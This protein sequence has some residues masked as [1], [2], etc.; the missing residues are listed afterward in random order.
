MDHKLSRSSETG[1]VVRRSLAIA[2]WLAVVLWGASPAAAYSE[3]EGAAEP[4][5]PASPASNETAALGEAAP[6]PP[7]AASLEDRWGAIVAPDSVTPSAPSADT[8]VRDRQ[9]SSGWSDFGEQVF[10]RLSVDYTHNW[11]SF[12]GLP[13]LT[14]LNN[15]GPTFTI[16]EDGIVSFPE[17]FEN[18]DDRLYTRLNFGTKGF[19]SDRLNTFFSV[20][21]YSDLDGTSSGSPF[22]SYL[23]SY[24]GRNRLELVNAYFEMNGIGSEDGFFSNGHLRVGRQYVHSYTNQLYPLGVTVMDG[25][26]ADF[27][28]ERFNIGG[29]VGSRP[30]LWSEPDFRFVT[31]F[32]FGALLGE[33]AYFN[34]DILYYADAVVQNFTIEP[35]WA[36]RWGL[37][38]FFRMVEDNPVDI[39]IRTAYSGENWS[40]HANVTDRVSNDDFLYDIFIRSGASNDFNRVRRLFFTP[41][42]PSFRVSVDGNR[43][44]A[45]WLNVGGRFWLFQ[46]HDEEED[47]S[48]FESS[49]RDWSGNVTVTPGENWEFFG[50]YRFRDLDRPSPFGAE[51]FDDIEAAGET[52]Y[53]ELVGSVAYRLG[54]RMKAEFGGYYRLFD[55]QN[56]LS[57]IDDSKTNGVFANFFWRIHRS[58]NFR[59]LFGS[60]NDYFVFNPDISRQN[61]LRIG[62]DF[63]K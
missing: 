51:L 2:V 50:E 58:V 23:D 49:F 55:L 37:Q 4:S 54:A 21:N 6:A 46:L 28:N 8:P 45:S 11:T 27:R 31:G 34:Y 48:G 35:R 10:F 32:N 25:V 33:K 62:F 36:S 61:G 39:G 60:D 15:D 56:R 19:G 3:A 52:E 30:G 29:Y 57:I 1:T 42:E 63:L 18:N 7:Q 59:V 12:S 17:A 47:T 22:I 13:S 41:T 53:Q 44:L 26:S 24:G 40:F 20:V 38:G 9:P 14:F 16:N 43:Q 5:N